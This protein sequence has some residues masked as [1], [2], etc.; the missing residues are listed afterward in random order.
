MLTKDIKYPY[1][2]LI[3]DVVGVLASV[4]ILLMFIFNAYAN[5]ESNGSSSF[6]INIAGFSMI[7][8]SVL[9]LIVVVCAVFSFILK[10]IRKER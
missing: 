7:F 9:F 5:F 4:G 6:G 8:L 1:V 10:L 2:K 3:F